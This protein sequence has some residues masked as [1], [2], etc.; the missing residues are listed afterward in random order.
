MVEAFVDGRELT[1][2]ILDD[3][4]LPVVEIIPVGEFY[5]FGA[6]YTAGMSRH[7]VPAPIPE[8]TAVLVQQTALS[9]HRA[10]GCKGATR[11]DIRLD[12]HE[13][14]WVLE[15]NTIPGMT[16]TSLLPEAAGLVTAARNETAPAP[17]EVPLAEDAPPSDGSPSPAQA[18]IP[19][20]GGSGTAAEE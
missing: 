14:P 17:V 5:D 11:V 2:G 15:I 12:R 6:K 18:T 3:N 20:A 9:V 8:S 19:E 1:V 13:Q 4:A 7:L 16:E 10:L